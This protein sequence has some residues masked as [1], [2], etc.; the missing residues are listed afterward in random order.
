MILLVGYF[1][2]YYQLYHKTKLAKVLLI[3]E[4]IFRV[5]SFVS[6]IIDLIK[7]GG[8]IHDLE[9]LYYVP[10]FLSIILYFSKGIMAKI[11]F[12]ILSSFIIFLIIYL[13]PLYFSVVFG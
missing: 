10:V 4:V 11:L 8:F 9:Y 6:L 12:I 7:D 1:F 5:V 13:F 2:Y 3:C